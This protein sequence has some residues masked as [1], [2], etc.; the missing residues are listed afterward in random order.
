MGPQKMRPNRKVILFVCT[1]LQ[2]MHP[3]SASRKTKTKSKSLHRTLHVAILLYVAAPALHFVHSLSLPVL[4]RGCLLARL[5]SVSST[6]FSHSFFTSS[7]IYFICMSLVWLNPLK[8]VSVSAFIIIFPLKI[9]WDFQ[10][11]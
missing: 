8:M 11:E 7:Y 5:H 2:S 10:F 6:F 3:P 4:F 9:N 1:T